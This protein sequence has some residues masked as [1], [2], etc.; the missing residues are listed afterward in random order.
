MLPRLLDGLGRQKYVGRLLWVE[1]WVGRGRK[2]GIHIRRGFPADER[3]AALALTLINFAARVNNLWFQVPCPVPHE[4]ASA[5]RRR[6]RKE[7]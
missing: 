4:W 5:C 2:G 1:W 7:C 3:H 6:L